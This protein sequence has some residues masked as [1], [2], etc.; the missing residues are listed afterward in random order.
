[1]TERKDSNPKQAYGDMK[2][3]VSSVPMAFFYGVAVAMAEGGMKY[4]RHNYRDMGC[5]HSTYFDAAVGH[6]V[7]WWEG[8]DID[9]E[10][11]VHHLLKAAASIAVMYDSIVMKND[12]DD[13]P[14]RYPDGVHLRINPAIAK[15]KEKYPNP[16]EPFTQKRK[17]AE[18]A[19]VP[20]LPDP[21]PFDKNDLITRLVDGLPSYKRMNEMFGTKKRKAIANRELK[22]G[23][24]VHVD[25]VQWVSDDAPTAEEIDRVMLH[26]F[27][28]ADDPDFLI[29]EKKDKKRMTPE[30]HRRIEDV[31]GMDVHP[32]EV[33]MP[34]VNFIPEPENKEL[35]KIP[36]Y[37]GKP[38]S[39]IEAEMRQAEAEK[40]LDRL[41][42]QFER[43]YLEAAGR[44]DGFRPICDECPDQ[45]YCQSIDAEL[46]CSDCKYYIPRGMACLKAK[47]L[48]QRDP[49]VGDCPFF[50]RKTDG[51]NKQD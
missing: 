22:A 29:V 23:D 24:M 8:E 44:R 40:H 28:Q 30:I 39:Q 9:E 14:I 20:L 49:K 6:L 48:L 21:F 11:G 13:R 32:L 26:I 10:S 47:L 34:G 12:N 1:M 5:K 2:V 37:G 42:K 19:I 50:E 18:N 3:G 15:L 38:S 33:A 4:G 41:C 17:D 46:H 35:G 27:K 31:L 45:L 7:S 25:D 36:G 43:Q 51:E 16:V